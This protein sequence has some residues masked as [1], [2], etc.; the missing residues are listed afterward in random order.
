MKEVIARIKAET[1]IFFKNVIAVAITLASAGTAL[2]AAEHLVPNF[3][4]PPLAY[5]A[6][7]WMIV[8]GI[9]AAF[10]AKTAKV[11]VPV[12][13]PTFPTETPKPNA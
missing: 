3:K 8:G 1:P 10:V 5:T 4:L 2:L 13:I 6:S 11:D 9:V 12:E 7:Q